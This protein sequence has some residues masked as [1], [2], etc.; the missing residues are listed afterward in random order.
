MQVLSALLSCWPA[1]LVWLLIVQ[2]QLAW[3][4]KTLRQEP[5]FESYPWV[6]RALLWLA[7]HVWPYTKVA[8]VRD[9]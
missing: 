2:P 7:D 6:I 5:S 3:Y 9:H 4:S 1:L 8:R